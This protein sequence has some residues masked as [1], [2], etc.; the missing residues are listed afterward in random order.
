MGGWVKVPLLAIFA[1]V[2]ATR[3]SLWTFSGSYYVAL[4]LASLRYSLG[5]WWLASRGR[6]IFL[7]GC[8]AAHSNAVPG[9]TNAE[10]GFLRSWLRCSTLLEPSETSRACT[11]RKNTS[12]KGL[13]TGFI[14]CVNQP[15]LF[16]VGAVWVKHCAV[17]HRI[18]SRHSASDLRLLSACRTSVLVISAFRSV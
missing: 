17:A 8:F 3:D 14:C 18:H 12:G 15:Q 16:K 9:S 10:N 4:P 7:S 2:V 11:V 13:L 6:R 1:T 5:A